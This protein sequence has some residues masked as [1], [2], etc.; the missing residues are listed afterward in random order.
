MGN[1]P[2]MPFPQLPSIARRA[3]KLLN[4]RTEDQIDSA[5]DEIDWMI[6][7]Y[8]LTL[9][10]E[11]I[12]RL[13]GEMKA[14]RV[15][16]ERLF[17]WD[18][19]TIANGRWEFKDDMEDELEIPK[20][21]NTSKLEALKDCIG[22]YVTTDSEDFPNGKEYEFFAVL[23]L[24]L[25]ADSIRW[26]TYSREFI[27]TASFTD[28]RVERSRSVEE[29]KP[30][31]IQS[32]YALAGESALIAMDAV[33]HA[34]RL[35]AL[36]RIETKHA[37]KVANTLIE[38]Q[39]EEVKKRSLKATKLN[40]SKHRETYEAKAKVIEEWEKNISQFPSAEQAGVYFSE[41]LETNNL[42]KHEPRTITGW[43]RTYAK[44]IGVRFR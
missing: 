17:Q 18:G 19:G 22:W 14:G 40:L 3:R 32:N 27:V 16:T 21:E 10:N 5:A 37:Q 34:E 6:D 23:S 31:D 11:E 36:A 8:F 38:I 2:D 12:E 29:N 41:W 26:L 39:A 42:K 4:L 28:G 20:S 15:Q 1:V 7:E 25:L 9:K 33:C 44:T 13:K 43:L 30:S 35:E 24:V